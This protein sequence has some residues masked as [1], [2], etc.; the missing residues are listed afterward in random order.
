MDDVILETTGY[1]AQFAEL[2][3]SIVA[4][5]DPWPEIASPRNFLASSLFKLM[6]SNPGRLATIQNRLQYETK[7]KLKQFCVVAKVTSSF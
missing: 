5:S 1:T 4:E 2:K 7:E 3:N 6:S